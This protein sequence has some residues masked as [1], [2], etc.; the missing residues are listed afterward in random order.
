MYINR[1]RSCNIVHMVI[2]GTYLQGEILGVQSSQSTP[3]KFLRKL[4]NEY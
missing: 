1:T 3:Q 4:M 2:P